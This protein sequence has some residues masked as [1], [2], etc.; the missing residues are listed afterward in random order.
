MKNSK[1]HSVDVFD[2]I[3]S[4]CE[5]FAIALELHEKGQLE[6]ENLEAWLQNI[7]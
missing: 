6:N 2:F 4:K 7:W 3:A 5:Q 1:I